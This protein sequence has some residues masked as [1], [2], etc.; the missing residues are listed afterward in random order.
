MAFQN[1]RNCSQFETEMTTSESS[2]RVGPVNTQLLIIEHFDSIVNELDIYV[3]SLIESCQNAA[4]NGKNIR[5]AMASKQHRIAGMNQARSRLID[6][7][8]RV[9]QAALSYCEENRCMLRKKQTEIISQE[10][11]GAASFKREIFSKTSVCFLVYLNRNEL[12]SSVFAENSL[13]ALLVV[14]KCMF[15]EASD[16]QFLR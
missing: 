13:D 7:I 12:R 2:K 14:V 16:I 15:L 6:E 5:R 9:Q 11:N 10:N 4:S 1:S 8:R 3:E